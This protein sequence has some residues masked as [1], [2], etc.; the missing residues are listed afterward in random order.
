MPSRANAT[1]SR[2]PLIVVDI[3]GSGTRIGVFL[4]DEL[5]S[6]KHE[7][8]NSVEGLISSIK[9]CSQF[10]HVKGIGISVPGY[11]Q[12]DT[13]VVLSCGAAPYLEGNL[14]ETILSHFPTAII[15][16]VNYGEAHALALL[17][18]P[19]I[20]FGAINLALGTAVG[21]G[22]IGKNGEIVRTL[23]GD[24]WDVSALKVKTLTSKKSIWWALGQKGLEELV[25][26]YGE[27]GYE[28]FG[29]CLGSFA[30]QLATIFRPCTIAFSGGHIVQH[31]EFFEKAVFREFTP[32]RLTSPQLIPQKYTES[33][34]IGLTALFSKPMTE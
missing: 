28:H 5:T 7:Q 2:Y 21:L 12:G 15:N 26:D 31:W 13:G 18:S 33:A 9:S 25:N 14:R 4:D 30:S 3:G 34:L 24:N 1:D 20:K 8:V 29:C 22:V 17:K 23:S 6:V 16:V 11:V 10:S 19:D 27:K 32:P